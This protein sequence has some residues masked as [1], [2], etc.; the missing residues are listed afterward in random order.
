MRLDATSARVAARF[1]PGPLTMLVAARAGLPLPIVG[2][3][4]LV[5]VRVPDHPVARALARLAGH[6]LTATSANVSGSAATAD[7]DEVA[8]QLPQVDVLD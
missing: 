3:R 7:P 8:R 5:G 6:A 2:E 4:G 1:W